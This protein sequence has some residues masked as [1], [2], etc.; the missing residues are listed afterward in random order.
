MFI[1]VF[2]FQESENIFLFP[3]VNNFKNNICRVKYSSVFFFFLIAS[4]WQPLIKMVLKGTGQGS[5]SRGNQHSQIRTAHG[6]LTILEKIDAF[7]ISIYTMKWKMI[8]TH[9]WR[10]MSLLSKHQQWPGTQQCRHHL[11]L[12]VSIRL[13]WHDKYVKFIYL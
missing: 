12:L 1:I 11:E 3:K 4:L 9:T 10:F 7:S 8:K 13:P 2:N 6:H 5:G